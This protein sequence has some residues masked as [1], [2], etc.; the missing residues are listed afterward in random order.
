MR[1]KSS[2]RIWQFYSLHRRVAKESLVTILFT[3]SCLVD[4]INRQGTLFCLRH[5][6]QPGTSPPKVR[7]SASLYVLLLATVVLSGSLQLED[8]FVPAVPLVFFFNQDTRT[9]SPGRRQDLLAKLTTSIQ[10]SIGMFEVTTSNWSLEP[11]I[12]WSLFEHGL[13]PASPFVENVCFS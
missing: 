6:S 3:R 8:S 13:E 1:T 4:Q 12:S 7:I 5:V 10:P 9:S 2:T 11:P